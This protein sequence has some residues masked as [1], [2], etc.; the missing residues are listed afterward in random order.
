MVTRVFR[1]RELAHVRDT[2]HAFD[3]AR[4][5]LAKQRGDAVSDEKKR[6][7]FINRRLASLLTL[8]RIG[9]GLITMLTS[10]APVDPQPMKELFHGEEEP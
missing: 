8:S 6:I 3:S 2:I 4:K 9:E 5:Q 7:R 10:G 1:E